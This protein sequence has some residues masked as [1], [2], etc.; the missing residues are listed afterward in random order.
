MRLIICLAW[1]LLL[2]GCERQG[3]TRP[4]SNGVEVNAPGVNVEVKKGSG[5]KVQAPGVHV[6]V[7]KKNP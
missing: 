4:Q 3:P 1:V 5:V 7:Q 2:A 6:D